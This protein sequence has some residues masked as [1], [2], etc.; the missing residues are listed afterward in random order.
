MLWVTVRVRAKTVKE[1]KVG[2]TPTKH[3]SRPSNSPPREQCHQFE[4]SAKLSST[5]GGFKDQLV[6]L[7]VPISHNRLVL[8]VEAFV[9]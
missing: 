3:Y 6:K 8:L 5:V 4:N 2:W 9:W 7:E 1:Q